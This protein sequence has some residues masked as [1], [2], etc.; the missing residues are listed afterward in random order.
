MTSAQLQAFITV[1]KVNSFTTA[2]LV[3][4]ISQSAVSHA[5]KSAEK[6]LG[7]SLFTRGKAQ[8]VLTEFG[9]KILPKAHS[10]LGLLES[11]RQTANETKNLQQGVLKIGSFGPSFSTRLLPIILRE[12]KRLYP[13]INVYVEEGED[14]LIKEW[15]ANRKVDL[16]CIILPEQELDHIYL[17]TDKMS[18]VVSVDHALAAKSNVELQE[19]CEFPFI[20]TEG[21]TG[22]MVLELF[23]RARFCPNIQYNNIQI[24][25]MLAMV[26]SGAGVSITAE[27]SIP[28]ENLGKAGSY[29]IRPLL[30]VVKRE[31]G[32]AMQ[33]IEHLSPAAEAF[34][35]VT[36]KLQNAGKFNY[37]D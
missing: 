28:I 10:V 9:Q 19:L 34:V 1:A 17:T 13:N 8:I 16:G 26:S 27:L 7:V 15:I 33:D 35:K 32:L 25:S 4:G 14:H 36:S 24:M 23:K 31:I 2:A 11:I 29:V 12:Y 20:L 37:L 22:K 21:T 6:D 5:I 30:P 3:L 18:V